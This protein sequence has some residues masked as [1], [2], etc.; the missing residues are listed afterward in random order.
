MFQ[1]N[2]T[3]GVDSGVHVTDVTNASRTMLMNIETLQWDNRL[4]DFFRI[5]KKVLPQIKTCSEIYGY[6]NAGLLS[7]VPIASI[8][9]DQQAA[10]LGQLCIQPGSITCSYNEGCS[11]IFNTGQEVVDSDFGLLSTV[12]YKLGPDADVFYALEGT[13]PCAGT[14]I[15]WLSDTLMI[16][17][18]KV[19]NNS[20]SNPSTL[21][22]SL[23]DPQVI[24]ASCQNYPG[25]FNSIMNNNVKICGGRLNDEITF[26]PAFSGFYSPFW[27]Y[28][29]RG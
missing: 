19:L 6:V 9:G 26:V 3:G 23:S 16:P 14:A 27:K 13:A 24:S 11:M 8:M 18:K 25:H 7:G 5:P 29:S 2:L 17:T 28:T 21:V 10:L 22:H 1:K 15:N 12:A 20:S 4:T